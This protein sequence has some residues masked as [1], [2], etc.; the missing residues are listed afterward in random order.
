MGRVGKVGPVWSVFNRAAVAA[1][2]ICAGG[3]SI[4]DARVVRL[5]IERREPVLNGRS[6]DAAGPYEKLVGKVDFALDPR[7][8]PNEAVDDLKLAPRNAQGEVEFSADF[9]LLKPADP[10]R[11]NG[12]LLMAFVMA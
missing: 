10:R 5:R 1:M 11:G 2:V 6:F 8:P 12:R 4:A 9:Y 7:L 3:A